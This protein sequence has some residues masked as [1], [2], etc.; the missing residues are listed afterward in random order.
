MN[1]WCCPTTSQITYHFSEF[2]ILETLH[3]VE[4]LFKSL[5]RVHCELTKVCPHVKEFTRNKYTIFPKYGRKA[6]F[7][8]RIVFS[9]STTNGS[10]YHK[11][12]PP[13]WSGPH[14]G[15]QCLSTLDCKRILRYTKMPIPSG[16]G[17]HG[18]WPKGEYGTG[19][20]RA[21]HFSILETEGHWL[22]APTAT[23]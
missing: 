11:T 20:L 15:R 9:G 19:L 2:G 13:T 3:H 17:I 10:Q 6:L 5:T 14:S 1:S 22:A 8:Q 4:E 23:R 16:G 12:V 21:D 7:W 18:V